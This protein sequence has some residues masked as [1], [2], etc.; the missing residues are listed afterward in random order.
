MVL[1]AWA[2]VS[3]P[4]CLI[5]SGDGRMLANAGLKIFFQIPE[6]QTTLRNGKK[7]LEKKQKWSL[8]FIIWTALY[9]LG[10]SNSNRFNFNY[11]CL[12]KHSLIFFNFLVL[13]ALRSTQRVNIIN[14]HYLNQ[15]DFI[16]KF[17]CM[18]FV[19]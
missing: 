14:D 16:C 3:R 1:Y 4:I 12:I 9:N 18:S 10:R 7:I 19:F 13:Q 11:L 2:I 17:I 8:S 6:T 5:P 15:N